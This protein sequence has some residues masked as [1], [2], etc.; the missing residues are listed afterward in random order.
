MAVSTFLSS[1]TYRLRIGLYKFLIFSTILFS[2]PNKIVFPGET[3]T[4]HKILF[5]GKRKTKILL[6]LQDP[7]WILPISPKRLLKEKEKN[8]LSL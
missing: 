3:F 2:Y 4:E 6:S 5:Q 7:E 8:Y 1:M